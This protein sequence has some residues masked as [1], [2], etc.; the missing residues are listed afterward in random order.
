MYCYFPNGLNVM[1][2][3][4]G[5][6]FGLADFQKLDFSQTK[7]AGYM[8]GIGTEI[9][10]VH[11]PHWISLEIGIQSVY[12]TNFW[13]WKGGIAAKINRM[14]VSAEFD[15]IDSSFIMGIK[16]GYQFGY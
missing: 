12:W 1:S 9:L 7:Q 14:V 5:C 11:Y 10:V 6:G 15:V 8:L 16:I 3:E 2:L 13:E 4:F